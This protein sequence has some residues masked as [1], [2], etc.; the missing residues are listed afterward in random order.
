M[1]VDFNFY[2][3]KSNDIEVS[4]LIAELQFVRLKKSLQQGSRPGQAISGVR[5]SFV[6]T[7]RAMEQRGLGP[8]VAFSDFGGVK[9]Y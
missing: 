6:A 9:P 1:P 2:S 4:Y 5:R 3:K 8:L 7:L